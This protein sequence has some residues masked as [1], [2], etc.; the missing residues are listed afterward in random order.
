MIAINQQTHED[1]CG[2]SACA[3]TCPKA[4]I[5]MVPDE[6]GFLYP[7][8]DAGKCVGCNRCEAACPILQKPKFFNLTQKGARAFGGWHRDEKIRELSSSGGAFTLL[9]EHVLKLGGVVFGCALNEKM[10]AVH[11]G[12]DR[13]EDLDRL[14]RSKYVQSDI[15]GA[16]RSVR[17]ALDAGRKVLFVG[18]PCQAAG[19]HA[20]LGTYHENLY[21][22]DFICHGTPS[23][24]VFDA[25]R[26]DLER[27]FGER[28][29]S[30]SFRNKDHGWHPS[31]LQ[32]GTE[33]VTKSGARHRHF[34]AFRDAFMNGFLDDLY[35]R[36]SC[37]NCAFKCLPKYYASFTIADFWGVQ[38]KHPE[39][40]DG[41]GT[42]LLLVHDRHGEELFDAVKG[43][44]VYK[45]VPMADALVRNQSI[46]KSVRANKLR[47][48]FF[49]DFTRMPFVDVSRRY[50]TAA[51]WI[52]HRILRVFESR[53]EQILIAVLKTLHWRHSENE[54][55]SY[56]Q[57]FRFCLVGLT[58]SAV[59]YGVNV[60]TLTA[61]SRWR[62]D[63]D[64]VIANI[65]AFLLSVLWAF[66]WNSR[67]VF[68]TNRENAGTRVRILFKTYLSYAF[69]DIVLNNVLATVWI[70]GLGVSK[71]VSPVLNLAITV[72]L[73][74]LFNKYFAHRTKRRCV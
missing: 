38:R 63:Y 53:V 51:T 42:S 68:A 33:A 13:I 27:R 28:I 67:F 61:L 11:I 24:K 26:T 57:F 56:M 23:Q 9:A 71:Y 74:F 7:H 29:T 18:A 45:E 15:N 73:N 10:Q 47:A 5:S 48:S 36:P 52:R 21:V 70:F 62:L 69:T 2:C 55:S 60:L 64:Y 58:N 41:K 54:V 4:C 6:E 1:C 65:M 37:Y 32:L 50:L 34:P 59:S 22:C 72:P 20:Y 43:N 14:R 31:G 49:Q 39:L 66:Y 44:F 40:N 16:Y 25:Y 12:I 3:Q 30:F 8:V 17:C 35:L 19:L 46:C